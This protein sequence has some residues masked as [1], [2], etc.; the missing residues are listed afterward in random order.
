MLNDND[1]LLISAYVDGEATAAEHAR[2]EQMLA[3]DA[4]AQAYRAELLSMSSTLKALPQHQLSGDFAASVLESAEREMFVGKPWPGEPV[5]SSQSVNTHWT[6]R[7]VY[8][9]AT[10]AAA[11]LVALFLP[12]DEQPVAQNAAEDTAFDTAKVAA[13]QANKSKHDTAKLEKPENAQIAAPGP[14]PKAAEKTVAEREKLAADTHQPEAPAT[15]AP[16]AAD[17]KSKVAAGRTFGE[18]GKKLRGNPQP[19]RAGAPSQPPVPLAAAAPALGFSNASKDADQT[20]SDIASNLIVVH[21]D[22]GQIGSLKKLLA[23]YEIQPHSTT[24]SGLR[25]R[26]RANAAPDSF[27]RDTKLQKEM[28]DE[29]AKSQSLPTL[30]AEMTRS[31]LDRIVADMNADKR[32]FAGVSAFGGQSYANNTARRLARAETQLKESSAADTPQPSKASLDANLALGDSAEIPT[33]DTKPEQGESSRLDQIA[34]KI[35]SESKAVEAG[36]GA[37]ASVEKTGQQAEHD[38]ATTRKRDKHE[39]R[40]AKKK[41][42]GKDSPSAAKSGKPQRDQQL[43]QQRIQVLFVLR[44]PAVLEAAPTAKQEPADLDKP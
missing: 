4:D 32:Q 16:S 6:R 39:Q 25:S 42:R 22:R 1:Q 36:G 38:D 10:V 3:T 19:Q 34:G 44:A 43:G 15:T 26:V 40:A 8:V 35:E 21:V 37:G 41:N 20:A 9:A 29:L 14:Q 23:S 13:H 24:S 18:K 31:Q 28:L 33:E 11:L 30:R 7:I 27:S 2:A 17:P 5:Q 12:N